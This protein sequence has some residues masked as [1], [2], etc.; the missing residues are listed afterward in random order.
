MAYEKSAETKARIRRVAEQMFREKGYH[1]VTM[2]DISDAAG[3]VRSSLYYYYRNKEAIADHIFD[4]ID[5][6][7]I[8]FAEEQKTNQGDALL[9]LLVYH[10]L[11]FKFLALNETTKVIFYDIV[12]YTE[13]DEDGL[14]YLLQ[15]P[16]FLCAEDLFQ[17]YQVT[18]SRNEK[19]TFLLTWNACSKALFKGMLNGIL[20]YTL[21]EAL[22]FFMHQMFLNNLPIPKEV[23]EQ[24]LEEACRVCENASL[25]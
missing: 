13:F 1:N 15:H 14:E 12:D 10:Y 9:Q 24:K 18:Y 21:K 25:L 8:E 2:N 17:E 6:Q 7:I 3:V 16:I 23:Y 20:Q 4:D 11:Y 19:L 22:D 5:S